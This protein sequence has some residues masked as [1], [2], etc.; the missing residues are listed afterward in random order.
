[1]FNFRN[2]VLM[3]PNPIRRECGWKLSWAAPARCPLAPGTAGTDVTLVINSSQGDMCPQAKGCASGA[4][5]GRM[6]AAFL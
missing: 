4:G 6:E 2:G 1:M 5:E 3:L